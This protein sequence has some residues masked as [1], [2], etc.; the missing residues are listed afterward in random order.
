MN[1]DKLTDFGDPLVRC[2]LVRESTDVCVRF[3]LTLHHAVQDG[4]SMSLLPGKITEAYT[5]SSSIPA[6][7]FT[8][9]MRYIEELDFE[10]SK[11][12]WRSEL[13]GSNP[14][15]F[16]ETNHKP[17]S[18]KGCACLPTETRKTLIHRRS[19]NSG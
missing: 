3:V 17:R 11:S 10:A 8:N 7:K 4:W 14:S 1:S 19:R 18:S 2:A 13:D 5:E 12:Y 6:I 16:P 15:N 9:F